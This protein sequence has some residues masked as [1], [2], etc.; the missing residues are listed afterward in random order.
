MPQLEQWGPYVPGRVG[1]YFRDVQTWK[2]VRIYSSAILGTPVT[3][4][5]RS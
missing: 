5:P 3:N 4:H 2:K 1:G